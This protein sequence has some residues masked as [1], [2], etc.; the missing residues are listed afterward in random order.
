MR[1]TNV[2]DRRPSQLSASTTRDLLVLWQHP[3]T[4]EIIPIGRFTRTQGEF[5]FCYT[6]AA[7][8][9]DDFRPL[10][11][12]SDLHRTYTS[13][14]LP[15]VF[16]Q[17]VMEPTRPDYAEYLEN[18]GL[19]AS[20]ATP[21]E[22]IVNSGGE[23]AGD[24]LQFMQVPSVAGGR[25]HARFL[26]SGIRHVPDVDRVV[27]GRNVTITAHDH[28]E[29]LRRLVPGQTVVVE[30]ESGNHVDSCASVV[31]TDGVPLG[32]VP[33]ALSASIRELLDAGEVTATVVRV[34]GPSTPAHLRLVLDLDTP[35][36]TGFEFDRER[37]WEPIEAQ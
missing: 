14:R 7:A 37:R 21:W 13:S 3:V 23:R 32:W 4:R 34:G 25:A 11:G 9:I 12:L 15:A 5:T 27:G 6:R 29:A 1:S 28:E 31:T 16:E 17:R 19:E 30:A 24:T 18:I 33:R 2:L 26:A 22:Q 20:Q 10:P 36:P 8:S 35:A